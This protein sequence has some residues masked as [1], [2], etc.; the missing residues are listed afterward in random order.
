MP[1][2]MDN[3]PSKINDMPKHAQEIF[4]AAFNAAIK[5]YDGDEAK[6]NAVAYA[7]VKAKYEQ[8]KDGNW[9]AKKADAI[10]ELW[11]KVKRLFDP[12]IEESLPVA[13]TAYLPTQTRS[14]IITRDAQG[15]PRWLMIA[16]SAVVNKVGAIDSTALFDNFIRH[17]GE[18][19]EYP[20]LDF[21]H[22]GER[23]RF[24]VADWLRRDGALYLASGGFDDTELARG[25]ATGLEAQPDYWG[26]SIAYRVTEA[27]L[28]LI[29]E[30]EIP[31]YTDG[32]NNFIS[33]VPKRLAA[34]LF[35]ATLVVEEVKRMNAVAFEELVK[36]VG[37][38]RAK[39]FADQVD[40]ANRTITETDMITRAEETQT[41]VPAPETT[42][43]AHIVGPATSA[44]NTPPTPPEQVRQDK[45]PPLYDVPVVTVP[46]LDDIV[47]KLNDLSFRLDELEKKSG[48]N[49]LASMRA[50]ERATTEM[51]DLTSRL[52]AVEASKERWDTWLNDA[53]EYVK[54]E[55]ENVYRA[56]NQPAALLTAAEMAAATTAKMNK[57][58]HFSRQH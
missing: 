25:A 22:E 18:T 48:D 41:A 8:D 21:F 10:A 29:S 7:A 33:I 35:T 46:T 51:T 6:A 13:M 17:A 24:G 53:P 27:P 12:L 43:E 16:A 2:S 45:S 39:Q 42:S 5:Q 37:A 50:Q 23:V 32:V 40:D 38:E 31:V 28:M 11:E 58:P 3:P 30:G 4:V 57:G 14:L 36:L 1:Y 55:A 47:A 54:A 9:K 15:N 49:A 19:N 26:S 52:A 34:N 20:V 56:R 44:M